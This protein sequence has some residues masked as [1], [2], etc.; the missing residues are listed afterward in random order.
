MPQMKR[1]RLCITG[2]EPA[3]LWLRIALANPPMTNN[4]NDDVTAK[5]VRRMKHTGKH[6]GGA[7]G[8]T[9]LN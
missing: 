9:E 4:I 5:T 3:A 7:F 1:R 8:I 6:T 2:G